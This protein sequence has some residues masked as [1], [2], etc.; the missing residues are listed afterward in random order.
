MSIKTITKDNHQNQ[1]PVGLSD[2]LEIIDCNDNRTK[3]CKDNTIVSKSIFRAQSK[4]TDDTVSRKRNESYTV[5][6][7]QDLLNSI[8]KNASTV[9]RNNTS[10]GIEWRWRFFN[11]DG[12]K[13]VEVSYVG[14]D[15]K[16]TYTDYMGNRIEYN[17]DK[18]WDKY[19]IQVLYAYAE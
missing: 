5:L 8:P 10:N 14:Y 11:I 3:D 17:M 2:Q 7:S 19:V 13:M 18:S 1:L 16:R 9:K 6:S 15:N 12:R 4:D